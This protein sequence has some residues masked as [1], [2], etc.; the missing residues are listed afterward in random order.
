[1]GAGW[2]MIGRGLGCACLRDEVNIFPVAV[3]SP[4]SWQVLQIFIHL[5]PVQPAT[6]AVCFFY[7]T[8]SRACGSCGLADRALSPLAFVGWHIELLLLWLQLCP[9]LVIVVRLI[10]VTS[11]LL[12]P[13]EFSSADTW[14]RVQGNLRI[15]RKSFSESVC[16]TCPP[17]QC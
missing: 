1:V 5:N 11:E 3:L 9:G 2:E 15:P 4:L 13:W 7:F 6:R 12:S 10:Y 16:G 17:R 8:D 14:M